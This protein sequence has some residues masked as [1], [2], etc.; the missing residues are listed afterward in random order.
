MQSRWQW[1]GVSW[2]F[3]NVI[4]GWAIRMGLNISSNGPRAL[5]VLLLNWALGLFSLVN[6][7]VQSMCGVAPGQGTA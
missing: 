6:Q 1:A 2:S 4:V 3:S 7:L 5:V